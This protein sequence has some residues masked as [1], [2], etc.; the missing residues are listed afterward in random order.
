MIE[1]GYAVRQDDDGSWSVIDVFKDEPVT[2]EGR[3]LTGLSEAEANDALVHLT[4]KYMERHHE[5]GSGRLP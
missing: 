5:S 1:N 2:L 3:R 4:K